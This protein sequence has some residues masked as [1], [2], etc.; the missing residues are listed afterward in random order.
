MKVFGMK[1]IVTSSQV[2]FSQKVHRLKRRI[3]SARKKAVE[4]KRELKTT[5][6]QQWGRLLEQT[7]K[8]FLD[9]IDFAQTATKKMMQEEEDLGIVRITNEW[10]VESP[11]P[12]TT[13]ETQPRMDSTK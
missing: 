10:E 11:T 7:E 6:P 8:I 2:P 4:L 13:R 3:E 12:P 1:V 9:D 5:R